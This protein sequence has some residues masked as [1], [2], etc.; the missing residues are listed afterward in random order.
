[1]SHACTRIIFSPTTPSTAA[2]LQQTRTIPIVFAAVSDPIGSG[3]V[4]INREPAA[5]EVTAAPGGEE[6]PEFVHE[7]HDP[8]DQQRGKPTEH[9]TNSWTRMRA[10]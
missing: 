6:M 7:D 9:Q 2:L 1:M 3:F 10:A 5:V 8:E 4:A